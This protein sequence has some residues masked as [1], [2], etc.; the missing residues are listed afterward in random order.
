MATFIRGLL[1]FEG[2]FN[3]RADFIQGRL[4]FDGG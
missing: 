1:L 2:G 4:K 3:S